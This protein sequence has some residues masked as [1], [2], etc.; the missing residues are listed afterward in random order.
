MISQKEKRGRERV[1]FKI[2]SVF[3]TEDGST[4]NCLL[5]NISM[6]GFYIQTERIQP[7]GSHI[8]IYIELLS[9]MSKQ[10]V[11]AKCTVVRTIKNQPSKN[12]GMALHILQID[13][14]SSIVLFNMVKYQMHNSL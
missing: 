8:N 7:D 9:G 5:K 13:P 4:F 14:D 2:S 10:Y 12:L 1:D 3:V 6:S 11:K